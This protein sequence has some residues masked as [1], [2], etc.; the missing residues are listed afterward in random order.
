MKKI[1]ILIVTL[2]SAIHFIAT[3]Q[4]KCTAG[5]PY[6]GF[7]NVNTNPDSAIV[8][9]CS[10]LQAP[11]SACGNVGGNFTSG[12][13]A[14]GATTSYI[15][16]TIVSS[17]FDTTG[18]TT[19]TFTDNQWNNTGGR[20]NLNAAGGLAFDFCFYGVKYNYVHMSDNGYIRFGNAA[21]PGNITY[22][23]GSVP[24][25]GVP[26]P[27][28][29]GAF[30]DYKPAFNGRYCYK[31]V[32]TAP[33]RAIV[34]SYFGIRNSA[35][36]NSPAYD[37][38][39][40]IVIYET[41][42][43]VEVINSR[44]TSCNVTDFS[45]CAV[46][47]A[48]GTI[49][50]G[51]NH[52]DGSIT[53]RNYDNY[54]L[55]TAT[56]GNNVRFVPSGAI[57][58]TFEWYDVTSAAVISNATSYTVTG[59]T[60]V[61]LPRKYVARL[62]T[63]N[64]AGV[65]TTITD[66]L[67]INPP[68][69]TATI[70]SIP[71]TCLGTTDG[72]ITLNNVT[73]GT[74][75]YVY[76]INPSPSGS[77]IIYT[78]S[79]TVPD[80]IRGLIGSTG[81]CTGYTITVTDANGCSKT[82]TATVCSP[83]AVS[84]TL[85]S[86]TTLVAPC[87]QTSFAQNVL[88]T[89]GNG[90]PFAYS[91]S[92]AGPTFTSG[93][94][95]GYTSWALNT[96]Y[97][98]TA[99]DNKGC[100]G[101]K[102]ICVVPPPVIN[103]TTTTKTDIN[104]GVG[105]GSF[106][107][108]RTGGF[109]GP[110]APPLGTPW[111]T[112]TLSPVVGSLSVTPAPGAPGVFPASSTATW[113]N[114]PYG[115]YTA[116][117][118]DSKGCTSAT[119]FTIDTFANPIIALDSLY[120]LLCYASN[121]G[122]IYTTASS[123]TSNTSYTHTFS[124][125]LSGPTLG[126][127]ITNA[128]GDFT[129]LAA[130]AYTLTVTD[131]KGCTGTATYSLVEPP[132]LICTIDS[133]ANPLCY[134]SLN[135]YVRV[136]GSGG[137][138]GSITF[139]ISP[140]L[141]ITQAP[142]GSFAGLDTTAYVITGTD[143]KGCI[144]T[145]A[146]DLV[147]PPALVL[148]GAS[149][150]PICFGDSSA[151]ITMSYMGGTGIVTY[152][153]P[154]A[155]ATVTGNVIS[156]IPA[157]SYT[158]S[159]TDA[160]NC[161]AT[162]SFT[163]LNPTAVSA[164]SAFD[165]ASC[166][167][168]CDAVLTLTATGGSGTGYTYA[169]N[170]GSFGGSNVFSGLCPG[171]N[172]VIV[173]DNLTC[174]FFDTLSAPEPGLLYV[175]IDSTDALTCNASNDGK[176]WYTINGGTP[177]F[178]LN[179]IGSGPL[180]QLTTRTFRNDGLACGTFT[181]NVSDYRSCDSTEVFTVACPPVIAHGTLLTTDALCT[182]SCSGT[183]S[184]SGLSGGTPFAGSTYQLTID[185]IVGGNVS[186][187][188]APAT[189]TPSTMFNL[190][191]LAQGTYYARIIDASGCFEAISFTINE[192]S[193]AAVVVTTVFD[194]TCNALCNGKVLVTASG[195]TGVFTY[196]GAPLWTLDTAKNLCAGTV[197][198]LVASDANNCKT[199]VT[200][201]VAQP[202]ALALTN[203]TF[204]PTCFGYANGIVKMN[205]TGGTGTISFTILPSV[206]TTVQ[207]DSITGLVAGTTYTI[208]GTDVNGC[209][210]NT[211][212]LLGQPAIVQPSAVVTNASCNAY[213]NAFATMT[214]VGGT[215]AYSYSVA[216]S[217]APVVVVGNVVDSLSAGTTYVITSTDANGCFATVSVAPTQPTAVSLATNVITPVTCNG[218]STGAVSFITS[219]GTP[220]GTSPFYTITPSTTALAAG[221]YVF[222]AADSKGCTSTT[223]ATITQPSVLDL[224]FSAV[225]DISCFG[226][227]NGSLV[228]AIA[229]G[230]AGYTYLWLPGSQVTTSIINLGPNPNY[231]A[232]VIDSR[233]CKDTVCSAITQPTILLVPNVKVSPTCNGACNG[234]VNMNVAGGTPT[235][236]S[237][238]PTY[239]Y[240]I[241]PSAGT[242]IS[243]DTI[244]GLCSGTVYTVVV[245][246]SK[247]C[248]RSTTV[249]L[250]QPTVLNLAVASTTSVTCFGGTDGSASATASGGTI[251]AGYSYS[252]NSSPMQT[253][254]V[255]SGVGAGTYTCTVT[256]SRGCTGTATAEI[257]A[258][259][260]VAFTSA[261]V[262]H[263]TCF[264][265][266]TGSVAFTTSGGTG[267]YNTITP[268]F[269]A[270]PAGTYTY[271]V[272]D[273][274][275]GCS[276]TTVV[277]ITEP[278]TA[279]AYIV[280]STLNPTC[281]PGSDGKI[282]TTATGGVGPYTYSY[283]ATY[284]GTASSTSTVSNLNAGTYVVWAT[285]AQGCYISAT[286][287]LINNNAPTL[288]YTSD[289][290]T[291]PG[292]NDGSLTLGISG[293]TLPYSISWSCTG[294]ITGNTISGLPTGNCQA[295]VTDGNSCVAVLNC[296]V[297]Q[298]DTIIV[299]VASILHDSCNGDA[300][301]AIS[302]TV[303][304]GTSPYTYS[305]S[306]GALSQNVNGLLAGSY[307]VTVTDANTCSTTISVTVTQPPVL[308]ASSG[309]VTD[310]TCLGLSD[311]SVVLSSA[312]GNGGGTWAPSNTGLLAGTYV[313]TITDSK[314]CSAQTSVTI[315]EPAIGVSVDTISTLAPGCNPNNNGSIDLLAVGGNGGFVYS[316]GAVYP[317]TSL[318]GN[319]ASSLSAG[320]YTLWCTDSKGCS[321]STT[322][323]LVTPN[324]PN[325]TVTSDSVSCFGFCDG[326][327]QVSASGVSPLSYS[328]NC[329]STMSISDVAA[330]LCAGL[331]SVDITDGNGC[332]LNVAFIVESPD[333]FAFDTSASGYVLSQPTS[334]Q[335]CNGVLTV[336]GAT[337]GTPPYSYQIFSS[338]GL[339]T[340]SGWQ[341]SNVFSNL[342]GSSTSPDTLYVLARDAYNCPGGSDTM[343]VIVT[344]PAFL[345]ATVQTFDEL[346]VSYLNG[347]IIVN[348]G[349]SVGPY[350]YS[351][352]PN[353]PAT[354]GTAAGAFNQ[355]ISY[356]PVPPDTYTII[357]TAANGDTV[358]VTATVNQAVALNVTSTYTNPTCIVDG[359]IAVSGSGGNGPLTAVVVD[360]LASIVAGPGLVPAIFSNVTA[361]NFTLV[362]VDLNGCAD[363][364]S[365]ALVNPSAVTITG[366]AST[367]EYCAPLNNNGCIDFVI[368]NATVP[369]TMTID[370]GS[371]IPVGNSYSNCT[372]AAGT[373]TFEVT[374]ANGCTSITNVTVGSV[375]TPTITLLDTTSVNC[376]GDN[377]GAVSF[378]SSIL[379][380]TSYS[381]SGPATI[382]TTP[383]AGAGTFSNL[384]AGNF[385]ITA[386]D[387]V[388]NCVST[389]SGTISQPAVLALTATGT[390]PLIANTNSGTITYSSTG[391]TAPYSYTF[392]SMGVAV[393]INALYQGCYTVTV[394]DAV[395]CS[396]ATI[397]CINDPGVLICNVSHID[398][399][400]FGFNN[401]SIT[402]NAVGGVGVLT[403]TTLPNIGTATSFPTVLNGIG[404]GTY[405]LTVADANGAAC[406]NIVTV[407]APALLTASIASSVDANCSPLLSGSATGT[408]SGG[409]AGAITYAWT[410]SGGNAL[411]ASNLAANTYTFTATDSKGCNAS[412]SVAIGTQ[413]NPTL[414]IVSTLQPACYGDSTGSA[415]FTTNSGAYT[416][417]IAGVA[418]TVITS[419]TG[420]TFA[421]LE[422]GAFTIT[423][424]D[425]TTGCSATAIDNLTNPALLVLTASG[426][427][428]LAAGASNGSISASAVGGTAPVSVTI[429]GGS[430]TGLI[431]GCYTVT[432]TDLKGCTKDTVICL[433]D[434]GALL[435]TVT[436]ID[437]SCFG[438]N[439]GSITINASGGVGTL[440][441][442]S[443]PVLSGSPGT[444]Y[445]ITIAN[446]GAN[447]YTITITD[448][449]GTQC[450]NVRTI[451]Q[452]AL[453]VASIA[454]S[455]DAN[456]SPLLSGSATGATS[457]GNAG[458]IAYAW[459]P[460]GGNAITANNLAAG[461]Y[462]F[463]ATDS[464]GCS[465]TASVVIG[466]K[467]N[468]TLTNI[469]TSSPSC[470]GD[471][472][473][474]VSY[475][476]NSTNYT[477]SIAGSAITSGTVQNSN[478]FT[479]LEAGNFTI[480]IVDNVTGCSA[481]SAGV[482]AP[483]LSLTLT[484][485]GITTS[486]AGTQDG[487]IT[488]T[489]AN[490]APTYTVT[491][492]GG[493]SVTLTNG[494]P[495][496]F[497]GLGSGNYT[498]VVQ[499]SKLCLDTAFVTVL[500]PGQM[501]VVVDSVHNVSCNGGNN[502]EAFVHA[503]GGVPF[504]GNNYTWAIAGSGTI[505]S[506][507]VNPALASGLAQG[508]YTIT[509]TDDN[510]I[511]T[512]TSF[513]I[514]QPAPLAITSA[515]S[516]AITC[517]ANSAVNISAAGGTTPY[518]LV[519]NGAGATYGNA[520]TN[521]STGTYTFSITDAKGCVITSSMT[522][523]PPLLPTIGGLAT[524]PSNCN[525][526][527]SGS[528]TITASSSNG[529]LVYGIAANPTN[530][531]NIISSLASGTYTVYVADA[532][533]CTATSAATVSPEPNPIV[534]LVTTTP[535]GCAPSNTGAATITATS[536]AG[537]T[538]YGTLSGVG[539]VSSNV[540]SALTA[541]TIYTVVVTDGNGCTGTSAITIGQTPSPLITNITTSLAT[542]NPGGDGSLTV[543]ATSAAGITAYQTLPSAGV[544]S[545]SQISSLAAGPY[546]VM[547]TDGNGCTATSTT[548]IQTANAP[549]IVNVVITPT[550]CSTKNNVGAVDVSMSF[551]AGGTASILPS[552]PITISSGVASAS[553]LVAG[554]YTIEV[555]DAAGCT[556]L[557]TVVVPTTPALQI[558]G[559]SVTSVLCNGG[560][561]GAISVNTNIGSLVDASIQDLAGGAITTSLAASFANLSAASYQVIV[562]DSNYCKDTVVLAVVQPTLLSL[563]APA[564][565]KITCFGDTN[566]SYTTSA[567]GGVGPY[568]YTITSLSPAYIDSNSTGSF[569]G[570]APAVYTVVTR[571]ANGCTTQNFGT[572]LNV[573]DIVFGAA[574]LTDPAC[575]GDN[576]GS[577]CIAATGGNIG[578][579]SYSIIGSLQGYNAG[580]FNGLPS[581]SYIIVATDLQGCDDS[582]VQS[583]VD[584]AAVTISVDSVK[585]VN[586]LNESNGTIKLSA[587]GGQ[588][589][590][591]QFSIN[592]GAFSVGT[593]YSG[594]PA[595][596]YTLTVRDVNLC[597][598]S[599]T[600]TVTQPQLLQYGNF[601][602]S[603]VTCNGAGN[604][605]I[606]PGVIG[607]TALYNVS[608]TP[609]G[610]TPVAL[611]TATQ[612]TG[613]APTSYTLFV[614]DAN[615]CT[616]QSAVTITEPAPL[617][618]LVDS[619]HHVSCAGG[620]D[621]YISV[622]PPSG[623]TPPYLYKFYKNGTLVVGNT[624]VHPNLTAGNYIDSI[625]DANGCVAT[626]S[627]TITEPPVLQI[628][629]VSLVHVLCFGDKTGSAT[630]S[631][632][633]GTPLPAGG[634]TNYSF[635]ISGQSSTV[636]YNGN[637]VT[638]N[639]MGAGT[640][641]VNVTD[642]NG[643]ATVTLF[644]I[645][646]NNK[647]KID[648]FNFTPPRCYNEANGEVFVIGSGG[649]SPV[650]Y[651][652]L[653]VVNT[654]S[655]NNV[656]T[657]LTAQVYT[658]VLTDAV[659]CSYDS[660]FNLIQ[661]DLLDF[662]ALT[663]IQA[664][665]EG[666]NDGVINAVAKGGNGGYLYSVLPGVRVSQLGVF[667]GVPPGTYT[668]QVVDRLGCVTTQIVTLSIN[669]IAMGADILV[670][671]SI[672]CNS[673]GNSGAL[674][675]VTI[676]G[677]AP[678]TYLW[679]TLVPAT[680][681][682]ID[683][684]T[685][686]LYTVTVTDATGCTATALEQLSGDNCCETWVPSAFSPNGDGLNDIFRPIS[687]A[688]IEVLNFS[689]VDRW[690]NRVF[691]SVDIFSGWNGR[692]NNVDADQGSYYYVLNYYCPATQ[693]EITKSG[694]VMLT[695]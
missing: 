185:S 159:G 254:A 262:T 209:S 366:V 417:T 370:G 423:I 77:S 604:G 61:S 658:L 33:R 18:S 114:L 199:T 525:P 70:A 356:Y 278:P 150:A 494:G 435:C 5:G 85:P 7:Y 633:G 483:T 260:V 481:T 353:P 117:V 50:T 608:L 472:N 528:I 16:D 101:T 412:T 646:Q 527:S 211:T 682:V 358:H 227:N 109:Q 98:I 179:T 473:A 662:D 269:T 442:T 297:P 203:L 584:P 684:L 125:V 495:S 333:Q 180:V 143:T 340:N 225:N 512:S 123:A 558:T 221:T 91:F 62:T 557:T 544:V 452:P 535:G 695:R 496:T 360:A 410:P 401:G 676:G 2:V 308:T 309:A 539:I 694:D 78:P 226:A 438:A 437:D 318:V 524:L 86:G 182:D 566:G 11:L 29:F 219:G 208:T 509:A 459:T 137:N 274:P 93:P 377:S 431:A 396:N 194:A 165:S 273:A 554:T 526:N 655:P 638:Y 63:T 141:G 656:F 373:Y 75:P 151:T 343:R 644:T 104:C 3:A 57:S 416:A 394:F 47:N 39:F 367:P 460:S 266:S 384:V 386:T 543:T 314:L 68:N 451:A 471:S 426:T 320:T 685:P 597:S 659:G 34:F 478:P 166:F 395:G 610:G 519:W 59:L 502:G 146:V 491:V 537:I 22:F 499:D 121:D 304:G 49:A 625:I 651:S 427:N 154:V 440:T 43:I 392:D 355:T 17:L 69:I 332:V 579:L 407:T 336:T 380:L 513:S 439:K 632:G 257:F 299:G 564:V 553:G 422:A 568:V 334:A 666:S 197:Y 436:K 188:A 66:T 272:T 160:N 487:G 130:G 26:S 468:P 463:T 661:P 348:T 235:L 253:T 599:T 183:L 217:A 310:V 95:A 31:V 41:S 155:Y 251:G 588:G 321:A 683:S 352:S 239:N 598:V 111:F 474:T 574:T 446:L 54:S 640:Y 501:Q 140:T 139:A 457:G 536:A 148:S 497:T 293:G 175:T 674:N 135:G 164:S 241:S 626:V 565:V 486:G 12:Q 122:R 8:V 556:V 546:T 458:A 311:G 612:Y 231:C 403:L 103:I 462:T 523:N 434:P 453:M 441:W 375:V 408:T 541:N 561:N 214:S 242:T 503:I 23:N 673:L 169:L 44:I 480:T 1:V 19:A 611:G 27:A 53:T 381:I 562:V 94:P 681:Q 382:G 354:V 668:V 283:G 623:G 521:V 338:T 522:L 555:A 37:H 383:V 582:A 184:L 89:G 192:P 144:G 447:T 60:L 405:T 389:I 643:C 520:I 488:V 84:I 636:A 467:P 616:A 323:Q 551:A 479:G 245:T 667:G 530:S 387:N 244:S 281:S 284:P 282:S 364:Q 689:I 671:D 351:I 149:S 545:G 65:P 280:D 67:T 344:S 563:S 624:P 675:V 428:P 174:K 573:T 349:G 306:N 533:G 596:T 397:V 645:T 601:A 693:E 516:T 591:Y 577:I 414:S 295:T 315:Q 672:Q 576:N 38:T 371:P 191:N 404:Q 379:N 99:A 142:A 493:A 313:F 592:G 136:L 288:T 233:G 637:S 81:A 324:G 603:N 399:S 430:F 508:V 363:T 489:V 218:L 255:L 368:N 64:C 444:V 14:S 36:C 222:T 648:T 686:G 547:V 424:V 30:K 575:A 108:T 325:A 484:G 606:T 120:D 600:V 276:A 76:S 40:Q 73:G 71:T 301:G 400:C 238:N 500:Q 129:G 627:N 586:C 97:T 263:V 116:T 270:K 326:S 189:Y 168:V 172:T 346:C 641:T 124:Y 534:T 359:S 517:L 687:G 664:N 232:T 455:V 213:P 571:D 670:K 388:T 96:C 82:F 518:N 677:T 595:G 289:S 127:P 220:N 433:T 470:A 329:P 614:T 477:S 365:I 376:F 229:G 680:S 415:S 198:T 372:Y 52:Y 264:G 605:T 285:D 609:L 170:G 312:G 350:T 305:W 210:S 572:V 342:C 660:A 100:L 248:T 406:T 167:G 252:W 48:G 261:V 669:P 657:G 195:G 390:N 635:N 10:T 286:G 469:V 691:Q 80:T 619:L 279:V 327:A 215:G 690:G 594:L 529:G 267:T 445:P 639:T 587:G 230:T 105:L 581:G 504:A 115:T 613:L 622:I 201:T 629:S 449:N 647:I 347:E 290:V 317:G 157:G 362:T 156:G 302:I 339:N 106:A 294:S 132:V 630:I 119:S 275:N 475:T 87:V 173:Q 83:T 46:Q 429:S 357:V 178:T 652:L 134:G 559:N 569:S 649:V 171:N 287:T 200:A 570:L 186:C 187:F 532:F 240:S 583:L 236:V 515:T 385:T 138:P 237:G 193:A 328:W 92:P 653:P 413:A 642:A 296:F 678:Y 425:N 335:L 228:T 292:G 152:S 398:D 176:V 448:A 307:T 454:S 450:T 133:L 549:A 24:N 291:C 369:A 663:V 456:C 147:P 485:T 161:V 268:T 402:I 113:T 420:A 249:S 507:Q 585:N 476:T 432:A 411:V 498:V 548:S 300:E 378:S 590:P 538:T 72:K 374:D 330:G 196:T 580:C 265:A 158:V 223:S 511:T 56:K 443:V 620:N 465:A 337:G 567:G 578:G 514:T 107:L 21:T 341:T 58:H 6:R 419:Q 634:V 316:E 145:V 540:I 461:T 118:T 466:T 542:C 13:F 692:I 319:T 345:T 303:S 615:G 90:G 243:N 259:T 688:N 271:T 246:D 617:V 20:V 128:I 490:G 464:K 9:N 492:L 15:A 589:A 216:P 177:P 153:A 202:S 277:T 4:I 162:A 51:A 393:N 112:Y 421:G 55:N 258:P 665:C 28:V 322:A 190:S 654:P 110:P 234:F 602:L 206:G 256:D 531:S 25:A 628:T 391:G 207:L 510:G 247:L 126:T 618:A 45:T 650:S 607:G 181:I 224:T 631:V 212:I 621:G 163:I 35:T 88:S 560:S 102:S 505:T 331:C 679:N 506:G 74:A 32:G 361:S 550:Q 593:T 131:S 79:V 409:N 42:N 204:N 418:T 205:A 552:A 298:P 250:T 482:V